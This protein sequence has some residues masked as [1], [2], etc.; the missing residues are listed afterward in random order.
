VCAQNPDIS[1]PPNAG[2]NKA[3]K[4]DFPEEKKKEF[5]GTPGGYSWIS[6]KDTSLLDYEGCEMVFIGAKGEI[7]G[8]AL[9]MWLLN[10]LPSEHPGAQKGYSLR[11]RST[12]ACKQAV[13][14]TTLHRRLHVE[15]HAQQTLPAGACQQLWKVLPG[16]WMT[17]ACSAPACTAAPGM[18]AAAMADAS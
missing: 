5:E 4:A 12:R 8:A 18:R 10:P 3:Q 17:S 14:H 2:L 15:S 7:E 11:M 6:A 13:V 1:S 16:M 9:L